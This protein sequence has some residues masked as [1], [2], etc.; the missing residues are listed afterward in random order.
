M[1]S[2]EDIDYAINETLKAHPEFMEQY[3]IT[4]KQT[5]QRGVNLKNFTS[6]NGARNKMANAKE[7]DFLEFII[8]EIIKI[9]NS[10]IIF[11]NQ[12]ISDYLVNFVC[13]FLHFF[14]DVS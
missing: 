4:L 9:Y 2:I 12:E 8:T 6:K 13:F 5:I 11:A 7:A 1:V 10:S 14:T 3:P